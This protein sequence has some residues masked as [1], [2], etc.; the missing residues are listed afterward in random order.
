MKKYNCYD[1][2][3]NGFKVLLWEVSNLENIEKYNLGKLKTDFLGALTGAAWI[4]PLALAFGANSPFGA[5]AGL[6]GAV[7]SCVIGASNPRKIPSPNPAVFVV[8]FYAANTIGLSGAMLSC[9]I[10]GVFLM[11]T[12]SIQL[13]KSFFKIS[14]A[15][16][17]GITFAIAVVLCITQ[18]NYYFGIGVPQGTAFDTLASYRSFGFHPNWRGIL[19]G[20]ITLVTMI[21]FPIKFKK[22]SKRLPASA[23]SI[24]VTTL[25]NLLLN[26]NAEKTAIEEV[27]SFS[28]FLFPSM[29]EISLFEANG[30]VMLQSLVY[31]VAL[32][33]IYFTETLLKENK[34]STIRHSLAFKGLSAV[35]CP[36][37][38]GMVGGETQSY[39]ATRL[40]GVLCGAVMMIFAVVAHPFITR[41]PTATL[42]VIIICTAWQSVQYKSIKTIFTKPGAVIKV[43]MFL[44]IVAV[45][46]VW[47]II[48]V[49]VIVSIVCFL[50]CFKLKFDKKSDTD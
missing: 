20:T 40:T 1:I 24:V 32:V 7:V 14:Q 4:F 42:A 38:E 27:G 46:V 30:T 15:A 23:V 33:M 21:T 36:V 48:Y 9:I 41:V 47:D 2:I 28:R 18:V 11:F 50:R 29:G 5:A 6:V 8:L 12:A 19:F 31:A 44:L 49:I 13:N 37:C 25:L 39:G 35:L 34:N 43:L 22:L 3:I 16:L 10:A 45:G 26:P 17:G